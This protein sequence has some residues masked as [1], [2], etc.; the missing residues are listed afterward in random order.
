MYDPRGNVGARKLHS[1]NIR[2]QRKE[3]LNRSLAAP[4]GLGGDPTNVRCPILNPSRDE[5]S[6]AMRMCGWMDGPTSPD[7][8]QTYRLISVRIRKVMQDRDVFL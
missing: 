5:T 1:P 7:R 8:S 4:L 2:G 6:V 3:S